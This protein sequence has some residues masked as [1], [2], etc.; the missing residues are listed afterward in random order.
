MKIKILKPPRLRQILLDFF[1]SVISKLLTNYIKLKKLSLKKNL[2]AVYQ[3][4]LS[5]K[6]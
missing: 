1:N 4:G 6:L 2:G 3:W 5:S